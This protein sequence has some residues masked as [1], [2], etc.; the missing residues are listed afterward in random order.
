VWGWGENSSGQIGDN[1]NT[2]R[3]HPVQVLGS[4]NGVLDVGTY[5]PETISMNEDEIKYV[6]FSLSDA[7]GGTFTLTTTSNGIPPVESFYFTCDQAQ[8]E[9]ITVSL[10][11]NESIL[12]TLCLTPS[13]DQYGTD[14]VSVIVTGDIEGTVT[15]TADIAIAN[16]GDTPS[17]NIAYAW[18]E[19]DSQVT[20]H[21]RDI[22]YVDTNHAYV[23]GD[24]DTLLQWVDN[25]WI[26]MEHSYAGVIKGIWAV[27]PYAIYLVGD[28][29]FRIEYNGVTWMEAGF[30][31]GNYDIYDV[32][33]A[34]WTLFTVGESG[35]ILT[36]NP[37]WSRM[38]S[39]TFEQ[40]NGIY[41]N[42]DD[43]IYAVGNWGTIMHYTAAM[44]S[45]MT[46]TTSENLNS[47]WCDEST[48]LIVGEN[49]AIFQYAGGLWNPM[50]A[51]TS[52][53]LNGIWGSASDNVYA[54][55]NNG[56]ILHYDGIQ[57]TSIDSLVTDNLLAIDGTADGNLMVCGENGTI[58]HYGPVNHVAG[59][60]A[61]SDPFVLTITDIDQVEMTVTV[62]F[63]N[64]DLL[65]DTCFQIEGTQ[66][67]EYTYNNLTDNPTPLELVITPLTGV[68]GESLITLTVTD[69]F[70]L[71]V[72]KK[73]T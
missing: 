41:G 3:D 26:Y 36:R 12:L 60:N 45:S 7:Q 11:A 59:M 22:A 55:G 58:L 51:S 62:T 2:N 19:M 64:T 72:V 48:A 61:A 24:A 50:T 34:G 14:E 57:W 35:D 9:T 44:W 49:G 15:E 68:S 25:T 43:D 47:V 6:T 17:L 73:F 38:T 53:H 4:Q 27:D 67:A 23:G 29:N 69:A 16:Q 65:T 1:M 71:T 46:I 40:L 8:G 13:P 56:V 28:D 21:L 33:G 31:T 18:S 20:E 66:G 30:V 32:W 37:N 63:S 52:E 42:S 10:S 70:G 5:L 54:V 39:N